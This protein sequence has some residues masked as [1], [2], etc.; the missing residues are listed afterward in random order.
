MS[1]NAN[2]TAAN[3]VQPQRR[4]SERCRTDES[5][6][7]RGWLQFDVKVMFC[8]SCWLNAKEIQRDFCN[9]V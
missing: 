2:V 7:A 8:S 9:F 5:G 3:T 4:V 1:D 6:T